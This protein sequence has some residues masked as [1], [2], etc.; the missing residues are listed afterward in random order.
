MLRQAA[1]SIEPR[2]TLVDFLRGTLGLTGTH[3]GCEHGVCGACTVHV[4]GRRVNSCL[5]LALMHDGEEITTIEGL[6]TPDALHP[7]QAA[8]VKCDVSQEADGQAE[9]GDA[10]L[11]VQPVLLQELVHPAARLAAGPPAPGAAGARPAAFSR[12]TSSP[13]STVPPIPAKT[14]RISAWIAKNDARIEYAVS[15]TASGFGVRIERQMSVRTGRS[16]NSCQ[17]SPFAAPDE[18]AVKTVPYQ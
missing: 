3:V 13:D 5:S 8:F 14:S 11:R 18:A 16:S 10:L 4:N 2:T 17:T 6:G 1:W 9:Q 7:M 12:I 15:T